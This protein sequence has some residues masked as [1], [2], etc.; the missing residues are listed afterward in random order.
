MSRVTIKE[1]KTEMMPRIENLESNVTIIHEEIGKLHL[2]NASSVERDIEIMTA[3]K[4][5]EHTVET[6]PIMNIHTFLNKEI[7]KK[8]SAGTAIIVG[9]IIG[10]QKSGLF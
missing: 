9:I 7:T 2:S 10:L 4:D 6:A 1:F 3:I 8:I 5:L